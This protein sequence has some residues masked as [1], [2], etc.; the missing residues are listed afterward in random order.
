LTT[1]VTVH[2]TNAGDPSDRGEQWWQNDSAFQQRLSALI[3][4]QDGPI[5]FEPFHW[6]GKN[7]EQD[8]RKAG[9]E[10]SKQLKRLEG[11]GEPYAVIGHSHGGSVTNHALFAA[12]ARRHRLLHLK[13]WLTVGT[14][15]IHLKRSA[16]I[17]SRFNVL[18]QVMI[19]SIIVSLVVLVAS[20]PGALDAIERFRTGD[21]GDDFLIPGRMSSMI[22]LAVPIGALLPPVIVLGVILAFTAR[23]RK[24]SSKQHQRRY[25]EWAFPLWR[26]LRHAD[27][28]AISGLS[29]VREAHADILSF[30]SIRQLLIAIAVLTSAYGVSARLLLD[31]VSRV[32]GALPESVAMAE[33]VAPMGGPV[34]RHVVSAA[35]DFALTYFSLPDAR[36]IRVWGLADGALMREWRNAALRAHSRDGS[37]IVTES[38]DVA[39]AWD[40]A[41]GTE[42]A[43]RNAPGSFYWTF[44][45]DGAHVLVRETGYQSV[46]VW[47]LA[48]DAFVELPVAHDIRFHADISR[49]GS[50]VLIRGDDGSLELFDAANGTSIAQLQRLDVS[51]GP[52]FYGLDWDAAFSDDGRKIISVTAD[53]A[54]RI[55]RAESGAPVAAFTESH[56][57]Q[58][59]PSVS[60]DG[61]RVLFATGDGLHIWDAESG[62][63]LQRVEGVFDQR[64]A[65]LSADGAFVFAVR[66][67]APDYIVEVRRADTGELAF[68]H[69]SHCEARDANCGPVFFLSTVRVLVYDGETARLFDGSG[70]QMEAALEDWAVER[71]RSGNTSQ[72]SFG[73]AFLSRA[74]D[75]Y[76]LNIWRLDTGAGPLR[77]VN[78][79]TQTY[80]VNR[81]VKY[82]Y[83]RGRRVNPHQRFAPMSLIEYPIA[84]AQL[85]D[86]W[87]T[88]AGSQF[89]FSYILQRAPESGLLS[90]VVQGLGFVGYVSIKNLIPYLVA[91]ALA[92]ALAVVIAYVL[93]RPLLTFVNH[94]IMSSVRNLAYGNDAYGEGVK[95]VGAE[96]RAEERTSWRALPA[97]L[98]DEIETYTKSFAV[99]TLSRVR[100]LLGVRA[101]AHSGVSMSDVLSGQLTWKE[102]I[103]TA[104]FEIDNF[105]KL[106]AVALVDTGVAKAKP[107]LTEDPEL[108][109]VKAW[110]S[111]MVP[112]ASDA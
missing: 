10:L 88:A 55:A 8:R 11:L 72:L 87:V 49:D 41:T 109:R 62:A 80:T 107:A 59:A 28:E 96:F 85:A 43:S 83:F 36:F 76:E 75:Q 101:V 18:G 21:H 104:Y 38:D 33:Y 73:E 105:V 48:G 42:I 20:I 94:G 100:K 111:E 44:S 14:P 6:S 45:G 13:A 99:D 93:A 71:P 54:V 60:V 112:G 7:S 86:G 16:N 103:H 82:E 35:G 64:S 98:A 3:D 29:S 51:A 30:S 46:G 89:L 65:Q 52:E 81:L 63:L 69:A 57:P 26:S 84:A 32:R 5:K 106:V 53:G 56:A 95:G 37:R 97:P 1:I 22:N 15:F 50:R 70:G 31:D 40:V 9:D 74:V 92:W 47:H 17:F 102:L 24:R 4:A 110:L 90:D 66:G 91:A 61:A 79:E 12:Y 19:I 27:D 67:A 39:T 23:A 2:G 108:A 78:P 77:L 25:A 68:E 34:E 58:H